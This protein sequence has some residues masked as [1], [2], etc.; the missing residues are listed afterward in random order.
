MLFDIFLTSKLRLK[1]CFL[2]IS[3]SFFLSIKKKKDKK[4]REHY[5]IL[6]ISLPQ[7][8]LHLYT[9]LFKL[10][11][12]HQSQFNYLILGIH[13]NCQISAIGLINNSEITDLKKMLNMCVH[14]R[15]SLQLPFAI[16]SEQQYKKLF[17][18][19]INRNFQLFSE[20]KIK[21]RNITQYL[22]NRCS[23]VRRNLRRKNRLLS[24]LAAEKIADPP[25][26]NLR[27]VISSSRVAKILK[28]YVMYNCTGKNAFQGNFKAD[29]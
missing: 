13:A 27:M 10:V 1:G 24:Q 15:N 20:K 19:F 26:S 16:I 18:C 28:K 4:E 22:K 21:I 23:L 11:R 7:T 9:S 29:Q 5:W 17:Y 8:H 14:R 12:V 2:S 25:K 3:L 6:A